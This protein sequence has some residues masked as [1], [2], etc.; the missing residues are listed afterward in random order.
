MYQD[1]YYQIF[2]MPLI[3]LYLFTFKL[4]T[5][6]SGRMNQIIDTQ[7]YCWCQQVMQDM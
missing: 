2:A 6:E 7:Q 1:Y 4:Q 5:S 3:Y